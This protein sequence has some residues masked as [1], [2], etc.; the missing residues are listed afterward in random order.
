MLSLLRLR[1]GCICAL[2]VKV[3]CYRRCCSLFSAEEADG[4]RILLPNVLVVV[5]ILGLEHQ[6]C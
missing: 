3:R 5:D 4:L 6:R 2:S 1:R